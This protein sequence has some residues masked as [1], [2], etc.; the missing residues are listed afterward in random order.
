MSL[1]ALAVA[2]LA[3]SQSA[4]ATIDAREAERLEACVA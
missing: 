3:L 2:S 4:S 1:L